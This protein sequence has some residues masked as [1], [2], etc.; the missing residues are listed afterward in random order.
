MGWSYIVTNKEQQIKDNRRNKQGLKL[1]SFG[2][3]KSG[4]LYNLQVPYGVWGW[5]TRKSTRWVFSIG[6]KTRKEKEKKRMIMI[7]D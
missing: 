5:I 1:N 6:S 7:H 3:P 2:L 4:L